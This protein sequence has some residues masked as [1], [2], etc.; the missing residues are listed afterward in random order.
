MTTAEL[1]RACTTT[2]RE[3]L[4]TIRAAIRATADENV[5]GHLEIEMDIIN[6]EL[7]LRRYE[8]NDLAD[9]K[10]WEQEQMYGPFLDIEFPR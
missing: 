3:R 6:D 4:E 9:E 5:T 2:L 8:A 7:D 10:A 1:R